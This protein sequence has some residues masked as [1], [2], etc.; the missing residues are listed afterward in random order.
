MTEITSQTPTQ[1]MTR[2]NPVVKNRNMIMQVLIFICTFGL[3]GIYWFYQTSVEMKY[4]QSDEA[5]S[6]TLWTVLLFVPLGAFYSWYKYA[7]LHEKFSPEKLNRWITLILW[8]F[9]PAAVWF[10]VQIELNKRATV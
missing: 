10:L 2:P 7:E 8:L 6:P 3:Y 5:A 9:F 4:L 1:G